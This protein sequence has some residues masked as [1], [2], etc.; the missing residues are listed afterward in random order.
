[1]KGLMEKLETIFSAVTFAEVGEYET[2][3][4]MLNEAAE[5]EKPSV[6]SQGIQVPATVTES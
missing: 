6:K 1:M 4:Q 5:A 2:A 3:R